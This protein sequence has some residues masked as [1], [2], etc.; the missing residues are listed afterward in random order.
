MNLSFG[1]QTHDIL[2][3]NSSVS[4]TFTYNHIQLHRENT[5]K[6]SITL[7]Y[8]TSSEKEAKYT[9]QTKKKKGNKQRKNHFKPV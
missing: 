4:T 7:L 6:Q 8:N 3:V 5:G 9:K 2:F 1:T